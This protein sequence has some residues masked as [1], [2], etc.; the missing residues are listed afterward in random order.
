MQVNQHHYDLLNDPIGTLL[1]GIGIPSAVGFFFNTMFNVVDTWYAGM[2][3]TRTL[4]A[5]SLSFP[6]FFLIIAFS[7]GFSVGL[8]ALVGNEYGA[9]RVEAGKHIAA[10]GISFALC[11][12]LLLSLLGQFLAPFLYRILGAEGD[13][14]DTALGYIRVIFSG[15]LFFFLN[16]AVNGILQAHGDTRS[17]RNFLIGGF[18]LNLILDPLFIFGLGPLPDM[19]IGGLAL[20][21]VFIQGL[22]VLYMFP[23]LHRHAALK[24]LGPAAFR[25]RLS[26]WKNIWGQGLPASLNSLTIGIGIFVITW[27]VGRFGEDAVAAYG[28]AVRIEQIA[29]LPAIGI[30]SAVLS[31]CSRNSGAHKYGRIEELERSALKHG[32]FLLLPAVIFLLAAEPLVSIFTDNGNVLDI[33]ASYLRIDALSLYA[34]IV[35][36]VHVSMLQGL[37]RPRFAVLIGIFRQ[38]LAPVPIFWFLSMV[39]DFG[40]IGVFWGIFITTWSAAIIALLYGRKVLRNVMD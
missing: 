2:L 29:L 39:L 15:S 5:L 23:R 8:T 30:S 14:L 33:G 27:F 7:G 11:L 24:G 19:G 22:G 20:A 3:S 21:T 37:K 16:N 17:F 1:R 18:A 13:Y 34:Y 6:V 4:A 32:L 12:S 35:L 25:P 9:N 10:Q 26:V 36:F 40:V 38:F 31:I 28:A